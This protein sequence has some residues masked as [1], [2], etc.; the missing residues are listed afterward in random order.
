MLLANHTYSFFSFRETY[1]REDTLKL[2]QMAEAFSKQQSNQTDQRPFE[3]NQG[4]ENS[5]RSSPLGYVVNSHNIKKDYRFREDIEAFNALL[6]SLEDALSKPV[7]CC[8]GSLRP[9]N[10]ETSE[11]KLKQSTSEAGE[12]NWRE[13]KL[14]DLP[15]DELL[16]YCNPAPFGDLKAMETVLDPEV[17]LAYEVESERFKIEREHVYMSSSRMVVGFPG[18]APIKK[19]IEDKLTPGRYVDLDRY[20]LNVYSAGGFFK[21][22]VDSPSSHEMIGTLVLCLPSPHK[23]GE[24]CVNHDGLQH[25]FDFSQH[26]GDRGRIQWA[27]FYSDCLHEVKPVLDGHRVTVTYKITLPNWLSHKRR[28]DRSLQRFDEEAPLEECFETSTESPSLTTKAL[29][30]VNSELHKLCDQ[31]KSSPSQVGFLLKHKYVSLGLQPYLL[32]GEDKV[33]FDFLVE[34]QW[35]CKLI[36]VLS[37]YQTSVFYPSF[38]D[39]EFDESH[40]VY[41]FNPLSTTPS[42]PVRNVLRDNWPWGMR[43]DYRRWR[44][45]IPFIDIYRRGENG[46]QLV[47]NKEGGEQWVANE[48]EDVGVDKIY[49]ESAVIVELCDKA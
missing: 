23:G 19:Y 9:P 35:K 27:A 40:E 25:V 18:E 3:Y 38:E 24:L 41:E 13:F 11:L 20:K 32:K 42:A 26:S 49:L 31:G 1:F 28:S 34:K 4:V 47:R 37:R 17:R 44:V 6:D 39:R 33:L 5:I 8:G 21:P 48:I 43:T 14:S 15:L 30:K 10:M 22:H 12:E 29:A 16:Q 45:G 46:E 2:V 7:F 36:S